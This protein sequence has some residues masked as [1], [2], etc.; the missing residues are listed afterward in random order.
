MAAITIQNVTN[1][2]NADVAFAAANSGGDTIAGGTR[3]VGG[4]ELETVA[5]IA[6]NGHSGSQTVTVGG[7]AVPIAAGDT[8]VIPV[9]NEG[10]NDASVA[11]TY[12]G[13]TA[14]TVAAIRLGA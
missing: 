2:G 13:V 4:W 9:P 8:A 1:A 3:S 14:L 6:I 12:S 7:V 11:V 5:L 10:L